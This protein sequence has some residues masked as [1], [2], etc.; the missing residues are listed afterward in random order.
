MRRE[1][2]DLAAAAAEILRA[3]DQRG[4]SSTASLGLARISGDPH[5]VERLVANLVANAVRHNIP[6]ATEMLANGSVVRVAGLANP[7]FLVEIEVTAVRP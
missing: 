1:P 5:L 6:E 7:G 4:L 3:H 2:V